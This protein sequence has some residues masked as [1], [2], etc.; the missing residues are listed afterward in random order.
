MFLLQKEEKTYWFEFLKPH[1]QSSRPPLGDIL[2]P[3]TCTKLFYYLPFSP[4]KV[5]N[6]F[7]DCPPV[8]QA[9]T[10]FVH[11]LNW[12]ADGDFFRFRRFLSAD[13]LT[14]ASSILFNSLMEMT[15]THSRRVVFWKRGVYNNTSAMLWQS[16]LMMLTSWGLLETEDIEKKNKGVFSTH[17]M[18][19][20]IATTGISSSCAPSQSSSRSRHW[21]SSG[22]TPNTGGMEERGKG[23]QRTCQSTGH[24]A[25]M[26]SAKLSN[27]AVWKSGNLVLLEENVSPEIKGFGGERHNLLIVSWRTKTSW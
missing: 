22:T 15:G 21:Q 12:T 1:H 2:I 18:V 24:P 10:T 19:T 13:F 11:L 17:I 14:L 3:C 20:F 26:L 23:H 27:A 9:W 7:G 25:V 4:I 8:L 16:Q 6:N 5:T